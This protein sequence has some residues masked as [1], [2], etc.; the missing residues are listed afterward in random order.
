MS[1]MSQMGPGDASSTALVKEFTKELDAAIGAS[2]GPRASIA[3]LASVASLET[4][5]QWVPNEASPCCQECYKAPKK[6]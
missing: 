2:R 6:H 5:C 4:S 3:S 1:I